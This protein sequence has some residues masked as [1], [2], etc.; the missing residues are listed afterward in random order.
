MKIVVLDGWQMN[1]GDL[2]WDPL[3]ELGDEVVIYDRTLPEDVLKRAKGANVLVVN[4]IRLGRGELSR[5]PDLQ[6]IAITATGYD[7]VDISFAREKGIVVSNAVGYSTESVVQYVLAC[8]FHSLQGIDA[9]N[10]SVKNGEWARSEVFS[11]TLFPIQEWRSLRLGIIGLGNIGSSLARLASIMGMNVSAWNRSRKPEIPGVQ[12]KELTEVLTESDFLTLHL[13]LTSDTKHFL[14]ER[15]IRDIKSG[16]VLI[17]A[18]R[19]GL[20]DPRSLL[21]ALNEKKIRR[22]YLDVMEQEPPSP[23]DPL[24]THPD[25]IIT[26]H[27]AWSSVQARQSLLDQTRENIDGF[28]SGKSVRRLWT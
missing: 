21:T 13:P 8:V 19:G 4:K 27:L 25:T 3:R 22:A 20:V 26:P 28:L 7:N 14:N 9:H 6:M 5:L 11:Y 1:P 10:I 17:N 2:N 23:D 15:T 16:A 12:Q 18:G 24:V